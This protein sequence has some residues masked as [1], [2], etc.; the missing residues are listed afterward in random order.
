MNIQPYKLI[1]LYTALRGWK[2]NFSRK[3]LSRLYEIGRWCFNSCGFRCA[4]S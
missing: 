2:T 3:R 1:V 4:R